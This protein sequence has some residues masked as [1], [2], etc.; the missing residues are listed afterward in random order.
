MAT[1]EE[2]A[3]VHARFEAQLTGLA[4][5]V[6]KEARTELHA[7]YEEMPAWILLYKDSD[8]AQAHAAFVD[9]VA[10]F[11]PEAGAYDFTVS[12]FR[13]EQGRLIALDFLSSTDEVLRG[14]S[15]GPL[16]S[17]PQATQTVS[18]FDATDSKRE[19]H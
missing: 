8:L 16:G 4:P 13:F 10:R 12:Y 6:W 15:V 2:M 11:V 14:R 18:V 7:R 1:L 9:V 5:G 3:R 19:R 17:Q